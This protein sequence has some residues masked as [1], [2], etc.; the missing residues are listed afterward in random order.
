MFTWNV[1]IKCS[2]LY[3]IR[4]TEVNEVKLVLLVLVNYFRNSS[5]KF[6]EKV[7]RNNNAFCTVGSFFIGTP[8]RTSV[9]CRGWTRMT[10]SLTWTT[11]NTELDAQCHPSGPV[12]PV[13]FCIFVAVLYFPVFRLWSCIFLYIYLS[14]FSVA[15]VHL[16]L[17]Y[18]VY[19]P[20]KDI[21]SSWFLS[22]VAECGMLRNT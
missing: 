13:N 3:Y 7:H 8:C 5:W 20:L 21:R 18:N 6:C 2:N 11:L 12:N 9:S 17:K 19:S 14:L 4:S 22:T 1:C 15:F 16:L 10:H